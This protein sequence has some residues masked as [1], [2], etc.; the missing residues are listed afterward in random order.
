M[1]KKYEE[2]LKLYHEALQLTPDNHILYIGAHLSAFRIVK[3]D[4]IC[5]VRYSNRSACYLLIGNPQ[6][7]KNDATKCLELNPTF[8]KAYHRKGMAMK[9]LKEYDGA[10]ES[11]KV[12]LG[13]ETNPQ[14]KEQWQKD[15]DQ[16]LQINAGNNQVSLSCLVPMAL[17]LPYVADAISCRSPC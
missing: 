10:I 3:F 14:I 6:E 7:A 16:L 15:I 17:V 5:V 2:A 13:Y 1:N 12:G 4:C 9:A 11:I 8:A